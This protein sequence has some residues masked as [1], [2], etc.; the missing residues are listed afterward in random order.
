MSFFGL[1]TLGNGNFFAHNAMRKME[2]H[3][4]SEE[5]WVEAY[6][7]VGLSPED[8]FELQVDRLTNLA[9][10]DLP[11]VL[12]AALGRDPTSEESQT[13]VIYVDVDT[14]GIITIEEFMRGVLALRASV[15]T[16]VSGVRY[17][18]NL[19][20]REDMH[21]HRPEVGTNPTDYYKKPLTTSQGIGWHSKQAHAPEGS[22]EW[23][24]LK[25]TEITTN[26]GRSINDYFGIQ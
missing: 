5:K 20:F 24:G 12:A 22:K 11:R 7:S 6:Q 8:A 16:P 9:R 3:N 1:T 15:G 2:I 17:T 23:H 4:I 26:E 10:G 13:F 21:R 25:Q 19:K 18:S 14:S